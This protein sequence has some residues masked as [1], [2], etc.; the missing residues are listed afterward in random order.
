MQDIWYITGG[1]ENRVEKFL[2]TSQAD[3]DILFDCMTVDRRLSG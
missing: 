1:F 2:N 3:I